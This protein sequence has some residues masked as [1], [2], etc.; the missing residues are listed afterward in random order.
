MIRVVYALFRLRCLT[1]LLVE[2]LVALIDV[3]DG[4]VRVVLLLALLLAD[5]VCERNSS[6]QM[7]IMSCEIREL[8]SMGGGKRW[9]RDVDLLLVDLSNNPINSILTRLVIPISE[10]I[11]PAI[12]IF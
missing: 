9:S 5:T 4:L 10:R 2:D 12:Q 6:L 3:R 1:H 8:R 11:S 7:R